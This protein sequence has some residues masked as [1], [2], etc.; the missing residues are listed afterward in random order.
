[1]KSQEKKEENFHPIYLVSEMTFISETADL[2][3]K[4]GLPEK[5]PWFECQIN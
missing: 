4:Q 1:M 5:M 3:L 2:N